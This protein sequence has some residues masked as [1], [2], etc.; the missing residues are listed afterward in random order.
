MF[1]LEQAARPEWSEAAIRDTVAVIASQPAYQRTLGETLLARL[2]DWLGG[3]VRWF[4][5]TFAGSGSGRVVVTVLLVLLAVM[6]IARLALGLRDDM[7]SSR[8]ARVRN[9]RRRSRNSLED[10]EAY[11]ASGDFLSATH[12]LCIAVLDACASRGEVRLH[13][14]KTTGDYARELRRKGM[15]STIA[16]QAFRTRYDPL[17]YGTARIGEREYRELLALVTPVMRVGQAA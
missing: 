12:A 4:F 7:R 1:P 9:D 13:P 6:I 2:M 14:S 3:L 8:G 15:P 5:Q 17:V 11:A 16:F 10:A